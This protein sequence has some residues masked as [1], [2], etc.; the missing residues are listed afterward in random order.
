MAALTYENKATFEPLCL[1][2]YELH[3]STLQFDIF[4]IFIGKKQ[5]LKQE[6]GLNR[7]GSLRQ[8]KAYRP[9]AILLVLNS[10]A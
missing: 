3:R 9:N 4:G 8:H 6:L 10:R 7:S 1:A 5:E 2:N